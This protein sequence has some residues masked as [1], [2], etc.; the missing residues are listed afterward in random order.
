MEYNKHDT[1]WILNSPT[2]ITTIDNMIYDVYDTTLSQSSYT[3]IINI[4]SI[5]IGTV[6]LSISD[7][8]FQNITTLTSCIF[9]TPSNIT[10][11]S[12]N[13]FQNTKLTTIAIPSSV[14]TIGDYAFNI[15]PL[16]NIYVDSQNNN[17]ISNNNVALINKIINKLLQYAINNNVSSYTI[18]SNI[19][20]IGSG[21]FQNSSYLTTITI[22]HNITIFGDSAF[23]N[24]DKVSIL[25][26]L[27]NRPL[28]I[29]IGNNV[30]SNCPL[31]TVY[32]NNNSL[33]IPNEDFVI[34]GT[35]GFTTNPSYIYF[36][37]NPLPKFLGKIK[38]D[39]KINSIK[40]IKIGIVTYIVVKLGGK[41]LLYIQ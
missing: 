1:P 33:Y 34:N 21:A 29:N 5:E 25:T 8:C 38:F 36:Y 18:P 2:I 3:T 41:L 12:N 20:N 14:T 31:T 28:I 22:P 23:N 4:Q 6:A 19:T 11:I 26:L 32:Y 13:A 30:F 39:G 16:Q 7:N 40:T 10:T 9:N 15:C 35:L 24:C 17:F 27:N 37:N